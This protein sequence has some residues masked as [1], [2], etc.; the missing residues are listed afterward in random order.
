MKK[1]LI[2]FAVFFSI[3]IK[4]QPNL[5]PGYLGDQVSPSWAVDAYSWSASITGRTS[6]EHFKPLLN[7]TCRTE[8]ELKG[9]HL[10]FVFF[11][12]PTDPKPNHTY[13]LVGLFKLATQYKWYFIDQPVNISAGNGKDFKGD[14]R[15]G[16]VSYLVNTDYNVTM[17]K[18]IASQFLKEFQQTK[19]V[20]VTGQDI[21]IEA[22]FRHQDLDFW[23]KE[24]L[25]KCP[26]KV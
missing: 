21:R 23:L 25:E 3:Q 17:G 2:I 7:I 22:R 16:S 26:E 14:F 10:S 6:S 1:T 4:A 8:G 11:A 15:R 20:F 9:L 24:T 13:S 12:H 18:D 19:K 5:Y